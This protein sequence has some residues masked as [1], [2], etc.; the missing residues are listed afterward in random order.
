MRSGKIIASIG[1]GCKN[2][3]GAARPHH[4]IKTLVC[5]CFWGHTWFGRD[6]EEARSSKQWEPEYQ[7]SLKVNQWWHYPLLRDVRKYDQHSDFSND[8]DYVSI[9]DER[10]K[11]S[12]TL[13]WSH[14]WWKRFT[15]YIH[16]DGRK[17]TQWYYLL[18]E[19]T[20]CW[21]H[22]HTVIVLTWKSGPDLRLPLRGRSS[23]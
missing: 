6:Q 1:E 15:S 10:T 5:C 14:C 18:W 23:C 7:R 3:I 19:P 2:P 4:P 8:W 22:I 20:E 16:K 17:I 21:Y 13:Q 11:N 9:R 12:T